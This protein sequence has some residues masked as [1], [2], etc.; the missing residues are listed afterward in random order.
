MTQRIVLS[1]LLGALLAY[2]AA[3]CDQPPARGIGTSPSYDDDPLP[4]ARAGGEDV[5]A[6]CGVWVRATAELADAA[7]LAGEPPDVVAYAGVGA[8][9]VDAIAISNVRYPGRSFVRRVRQ[10]VVLRAYEAQ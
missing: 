8:S 7:S 9:C 4:E 10:V 2:S 1:V 5:P 6:A 3:A